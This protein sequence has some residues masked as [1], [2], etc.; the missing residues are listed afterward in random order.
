MKFVTREEETFGNNCEFTIRNILIKHTK[1]HYQS[2]FNDEIIR[3]KLMTNSNINQLTTTTEEIPFVIIKREQK[4]FLMSTSRLDDYFLLNQSDKTDAATTVI[5]YNSSLLSEVSLNSSNSTNSQYDLKHPAIGAV[6]SMFSLVTIL[7][8]LLVIVSVYRELY[9]RTITNYFIVSLAVADLMVGGI[10][11]PF[12]ISLELTNQVWLFGSEWCDMW[13]SFDV[14]ASTASI[15]NLCI[16]SLDRYWAISDPIAYPT[17]MSSCKVM[18]L[19]AFVWL[20]SAGI[21]F[22]AIAWWKA[23]TPNDLPSGMCFFTEDSAY[24][25][26][27]SFVSFYCPTFVMMFVYWRIYLAAAQQMRSLKIGS[28]VLTSNG[29]HGN[30]EVMTLRIHRGGMTRQSSDEYSNTYE[31]CVIDPENQSLSPESARASIQS[32]GR[33]AKNITRKLRQFALSKKLTKIAREQKAAKTL[34]IVVG[35]FI[36]CWMPFFVFNI[37]FGICHTACVTS[38]EIVFPIFTW[39]GYINSGMNPVIYSL[40]MKDFRRAFCKILFACCPKQHFEYRKTNNN[41]SSTSSFTV[42]CTDRL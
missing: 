24:L 2:R 22:P 41:C 39:L 37:L 35:V 13:H 42:T 31:K 23:V 33:Q 14:L 32:P 7:G 20:C 11:M 6:L 38:P 5:Y 29:S 1:Y 10:V 3:Y 4:I 9:L 15:L 27:S 12:S 28:K 8:N 16:I 25:I 34:G 21:S 36:I 40:S 30:R 26:F 19:I 18:L 17:K